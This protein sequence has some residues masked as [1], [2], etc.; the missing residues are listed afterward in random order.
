MHVILLIFHIGMD[1]VSQLAHPLLSKRPKTP[2]SIATLLVTTQII[3]IITKNYKHVMMNA[4]FQLT[5]IIR[6]AIFVA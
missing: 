3:S 6:K 1:L 2:T 4:N 5:L